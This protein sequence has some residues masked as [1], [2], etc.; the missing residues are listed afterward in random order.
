M[1]STKDSFKQKYKIDYDRF[2]MMSN[3][4]LESVRGDVLGDQAVQKSVTEN[5]VKSFE[6]FR[7]KMTHASLH[8][9]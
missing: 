1:S 6:V 4:I 9:K 2:S 5:E 7:R 8:A 3:D